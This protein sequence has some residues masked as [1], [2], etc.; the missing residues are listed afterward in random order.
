MVMKTPFKAKLVAESNFTALVRSQVERV[1]T[2]ESTLVGVY[3]KVVDS[4]MD[5]VMVREMTLVYK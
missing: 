1:S 2:A 5:I 3:R 4:E